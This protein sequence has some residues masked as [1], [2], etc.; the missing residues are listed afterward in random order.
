MRLTPPIRSAPARLTSKGTLFVETV[1]SAAKGTEGAVVGGTGAYVGARG[2][3]SS[4]TTKTGSNDVVNL[5]P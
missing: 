3:F 1:D 2:T 5:E 4:T